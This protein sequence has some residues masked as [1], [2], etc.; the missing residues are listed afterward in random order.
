MR[1][2]SF[3]IIIIAII[4]SF[5]F[6]IEAT[7]ARKAKLEQFGVG[8]YISASFSMKSD[9]NGIE[10]VL[11]NLEK[12]EEGFINE[13]NELSILDGLKNGYLVVANFLRD[14]IL[15]IILGYLGGFQD[16]GF[17]MKI[18]WFFWGIVYIPI[19]TLI[20]S[21]LSGG[22]L[23][24]DLLFQKASIGYYLGYLISLLLSSA[25]AAGMSDDSAA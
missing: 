18:I 5:V 6:K 17:F 21:I 25:L 1:K 13:N 8:D 12:F 24:L 15:G 19:K 23:A 2:G 10:Y 7:T 20:S 9:L 22:K 11:K 3:I 14:L 16:K 4:T